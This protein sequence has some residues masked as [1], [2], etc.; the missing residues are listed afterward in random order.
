MADIKTSVEPIGKGT[1]LGDDFKSFF[2][3]AG[4]DVEILANFKKDT[5]IDLVDSINPINK[6]IDDAT[7]HDPIKEFR[8]WLIINYW[9]QESI[10]NNEQ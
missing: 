9:G 2:I 8:D 10:S 7:G 6:M 4:G 3:W 5:G 1:H